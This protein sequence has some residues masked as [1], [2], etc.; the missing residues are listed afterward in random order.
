MGSAVMVV[1]YL[2][3][4]Q[5]SLTVDGSQKETAA[6]SVQRKVPKEGCC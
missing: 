2:T 4:D 3:Y 5:T 6:R 1:C